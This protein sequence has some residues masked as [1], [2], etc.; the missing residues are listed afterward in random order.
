MPVF[1]QC[2]ASVRCLPRAAVSAFVPVL[3]GVCACVCVS[4]YS[5]LSVAFGSSQL[6]GEFVSPAL[7]GPVPASG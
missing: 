1:V 7:L 2:L 5:Y 4:V 6:A 3:S